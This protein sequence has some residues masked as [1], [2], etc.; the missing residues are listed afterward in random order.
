MI[1]CRSFGFKNNNDNDPQDGNFVDQRIDFVCDQQGSFQRS[2][3]EPA[4]P[5]V[6]FGRGPISKSA[7]QIALV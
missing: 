4:S 3:S 7:W 1:N 6:K 2:I 5:M